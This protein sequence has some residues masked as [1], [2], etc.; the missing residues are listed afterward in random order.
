MPPT[1]P[2]RSAV[3]NDVQAQP[4][5]E[6]PMN[7][8]DSDA[9]DASALEPSAADT[10]PTDASPS[11]GEVIDPSMLS[12]GRVGKPHSLDGTIRV[13]RPR[14]RLLLAGTIVTI[15]GVEHEIVHRGGTDPRPLLHLSGVDGIDA[16]E[17]LR[18]REILIPRQVAPILDED[19]FWPEELVGLPVSATT[20]EAIGE[21][22]QV[23]GLPSCD[24]LEV[25]RPEGPDLL[26]PL[27][28]EAVPELDVAA[29]RVVIDLDFLGEAPPAA[30]GGDRPA[31]QG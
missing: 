14:G 6:A 16:A 27:H 28:H 21:V 7:S 23:L 24:V 5:D 20:G 2:E 19:E 29:R 3:P 12:L 9:V 11:V 10:T 22:T 8:S 18:G 13:T 31:E 15:A 1:E 25:R 26:V 17:A 30:A 4:A